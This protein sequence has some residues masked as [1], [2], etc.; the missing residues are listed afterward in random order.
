[1]TRQGNV[2]GALHRFLVAFDPLML[3]DLDH[4]IDKS[5][6]NSAAHARFKK[7]RAALE[8]LVTFK[9]DEEYRWHYDHDS[10]TR[11]LRKLLGGKG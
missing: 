11:E 10:K 3:K 9:Q 7:L 2:D 1:M 6:K 5:A 4:A 8:P